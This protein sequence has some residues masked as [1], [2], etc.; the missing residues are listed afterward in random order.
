MPLLYIPESNDRVI[1]KEPYSV[2]L[3]KIEE[4]GEITSGT[5]ITLDIPYNESGFSWGFCVTDSCAF[6]FKFGFEY[7]TAINKDTMEESHIIRHTI[8]FSFDIEYYNSGWG[9]QEL[10][11]YLKKYSYLYLPGVINNEFSCVPQRESV[12]ITNLV[13]FEDVSQEH[14]K[15]LYLGLLSHDI[16]MFCVIQ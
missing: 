4:A 7:F 12:E 6:D 2:L 15:D 1:D 10:N 3:K 11:E 13:T 8:G 9:Y 5:K 16:L 14:I